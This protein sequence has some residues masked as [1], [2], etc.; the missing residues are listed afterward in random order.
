MKCRG[1]KVKNWGSLPLEKVI[2]RRRK[3]KINEFWLISD[4]SQSIRQTDGRLSQAPPVP[5]SKMSH[6]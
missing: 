3:S 2:P 5:A 6:F 1:K 4:G